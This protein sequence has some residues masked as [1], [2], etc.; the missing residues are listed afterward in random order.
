VNGVA[1]VTGPFE[2]EREAREAA[3]QY[4]GPP[5]ASL[6]GPPGQLAD[7]NRS[8][9]LDAVNAAGVQL[10]WYDA[11]VLNWLA[12]YEPTTCAAIA[13]LIARAAEPG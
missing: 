12:N 6:T 10:G 8:M 1:A 13:G 7:A 4:T 5:G 2:T 11:H 3:Q 9:L